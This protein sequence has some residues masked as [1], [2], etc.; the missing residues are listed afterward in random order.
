MKRES[1]ALWAVRRFEIREKRKRFLEDD[2]KFIA[3]EM[4][5]LRGKNIE[6]AENVTG[7][8]DSE[9]WKIYTREEQEADS[10]R[11]SVSTNNLS[12]LDAMVEDFKTKSQQYEESKDDQALM[13]EDVMKQLGQSGNMETEQQSTSSQTISQSDDKPVSS[14]GASD[15]MEAKSLLYPNKELHSMPIERKP[16]HSKDLWDIKTV[17]SEKRVSSLQDILYPDKDIQS[18]E[19]NSLTTES[20]SEYTKGLWDIKTVDSEKRISTLQDILYPEKYPSSVVVASSTTRGHEP[21]SKMKDLLYHVKDEG[22][23]ICT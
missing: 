7:G 4:T 14:Q 9:V 10:G 16:V 17:D 8:K 3:G 6:D 19:S 12:S 21:K 23:F 2:E 18:I 20:N 1:R 5:E 15:G 22:R 11:E 13:T